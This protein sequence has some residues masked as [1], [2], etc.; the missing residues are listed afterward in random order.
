M[1]EITYHEQIKRDNIEKLRQMQKVLPSFCTVF[2]RGVA[3]R[4]GAR[5][6]VAYAYDLQIFFH[7]M[8]ENVFSPHYDALS[9]IRLDALDTIGK[10]DLENFMDYLSFYTGADGVEHTNDE[11]GK[12]RKLAAVKSM[13]NYFF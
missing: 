4:V 12:A 6:M 8:N 1:A 7:Y 9:D 5:T 3:D 10:L 2:F 11:R 13:F